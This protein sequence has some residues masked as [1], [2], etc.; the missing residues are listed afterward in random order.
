MPASLSCTQYSLRLR[1]KLNSLT[2]YK[3]SLESQLL[4]LKSSKASM[5]RMKE[6]AKDGIAGAMESA[7]IE[8]LAAASK[9]LESATAKVE[10][11]D[12]ADFEILDGLVRRIMSLL[13][14]VGKAKD[15]Y[16]SIEGIKVSVDG[17]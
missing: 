9:A 6:K 16:T 4:K 5:L 17:W 11:A 12:V 10:V 3:A 15:V 14:E 13:T 2:R 8:L 1:V 7:E